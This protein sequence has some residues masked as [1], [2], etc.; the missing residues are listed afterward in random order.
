MISTTNQTTQPEEQ[1]LQKPTSNRLLSLDLFRGATMFLLVGETTSLYHYVLDYST[2]GSLLHSLALQFH[3]HPWNG[4]RFWDLVQPFFMFIVGV[5]MVFSLQKRVHLPSD[6]KRV[7]KHIFKRCAL[8]FLFGV[9]LH[10]VYSGKLVWELWNVLTQLSFTI[11]VAFLLFRQSLKTQFIAS[12][13]MLVLTEVLY[14]FVQPEG[15][16]Q[17]FVQGENFGAWMDIILMG[18]IN[19]GGWVTINCLPTAAHTI[20]GV[21]VGKIL[22][23]TRTDNEKLKPLLIAGIIGLLIGY[24]LDFS[25]ITPII[26]RIAT[27]SFTIVSGGWCLLVLAATYWLV[28]VKKAR[29]GIFFFSIVGMNSIFIY[30]FTQTVGHQWVND[31]V[32]IFSDGIFSWIGL[33]ENFLAIAGATLSFGLY[34]YLCY[35]LYKHKIFFKV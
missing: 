26:K 28:D 2:E 9:M 21:M 33:G 20:W 13:G 1:T 27:T 3:H 8:L 5:A 25:G 32:A 30:L 19:N 22:I 17:T 24:G 16:E 18:K 35:W 7:Q 31:F 23:S 10:C 34:W 6:W 11:L 15:F 29:T 12:V 14:R 4:L